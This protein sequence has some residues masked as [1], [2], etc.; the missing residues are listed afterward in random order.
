MSVV[1]RESVSHASRT[2]CLF[3]GAECIVVLRGCVAMWLCICG[4]MCVVFDNKIIIVIVE[5]RDAVGQRKIHKEKL[6]CSRT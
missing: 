2:V 5:E 6:A 4:C 1:R 3:R